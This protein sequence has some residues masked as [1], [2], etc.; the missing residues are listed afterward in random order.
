ME[1]IFV[2]AADGRNVVKAFKDAIKMG[3]EYM[4]N[5]KHDIE[6]DILDLLK[7]K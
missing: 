4:E 5:P 1:L 6:D 3:K 7:D 2:S